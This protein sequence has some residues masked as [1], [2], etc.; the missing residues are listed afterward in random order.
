LGKSTKVNSETPI[1]LSSIPKDYHEFADIFRK[2]NIDTLPPHQ[3]SVD[4][5]IDIENGAPPPLSR[6]YSLSGTELEALHTFIE[7]HIHIGFIHPSN[8]PHGA[9][10]LFIRK[11]DGSLH[12][13]VDYWGLNKITKNNCYP[14]PLISDLLDTPWKARLYTKIDLRHA[15]HLVHITEGDEWKTTFC[16]C[17]GSFEWL[18]MPFGLSNA[19]ATFQCYMNKIFVDMLDV[20]IIMYLDDI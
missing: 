16:T 15:Y 18:V 3:S 1:D 2:G 7:E 14:L 6:M 9:P 12:L 20:C 4:L 13:C 11:K 17:Y 10:I 19:P 5:K 8:S